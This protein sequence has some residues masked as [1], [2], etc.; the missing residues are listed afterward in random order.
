MEVKVVNQVKKDMKRQKLYIDTGDKFL[1]ISSNISKEGLQKILNDNFVPYIECFKKCGK[2][3]ICRLTDNLKHRGC[4]QKCGVIENILENFLNSTFSLFKKSNMESKQRYLKATAE[5]LELAISLEGY[6]GGIFSKD[7]M[8]FY[9]DFSPALFGGLLRDR[10]RMGDI[11]FL[12]K[13]IKDF[14]TEIPVCLVEGYGDAELLRVFRRTVRISNYDNLKNIDLIYGKD[15]T[16]KGRIDLMIKNKIQ[17]GERTIII[18]D[19]D[20]SKKRTLQ[21]LGKL[22]KQKLIKR[23][24]VFIFKYNI[25]LTFPPEILFS[26]IKEYVSHFKLRKNISLKQ[27]LKIIAQKGDFVNNC[28][29]V[30]ETNIDKVVFDRMLGYFLAYEG[31]ENFREIMEKKP[32][33]NKYDIY[34]FL[35]FIAKR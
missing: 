5:L 20:G 34:R 14:R 10:R 13:D 2:A 6:L 25:E 27:I 23:K 26:G 1:P 16:K 33:Y 19:G 31:Y 21:S 30:L 4:D 18:L 3:E 9:D 29:Q 32:P 12:L 24:D 17:R 7:V 28:S 35:E 11:A 8:K 15:N 22:F